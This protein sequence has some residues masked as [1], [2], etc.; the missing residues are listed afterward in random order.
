[1]IMS[2][3]LSL[4][5]AKDLPSY[6]G[7]LGED[8]TLIAVLG[9]ER[10]VRIPFDVLH[11]EHI[12]FYPTPSTPA[13]A[14]TTG[15]ISWDNT[16]VFTYHGGLWGKSP[17]ITSNW[18]DYTANSRFLLVSSAQSLS[19]E[20][21][22]AARSNLN[23]KSATQSE[24]GLVRITTDMNDNSGAVP[25]AAVIKSYIQ[26]LLQSGAS[27][28]P[29]SSI[30]L[31]NYVGPVNI[32]DSHG[33]ILLRYDELRK[34]LQIGNVTISDVKIDTSTQVVIEGPT[35]VKSTFEV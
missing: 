2:E 35:G 23:I 32:Q 13:A 8:T 15:A 22:S 18:G 10:T 27:S 6:S 5:N 19:A 3:Q 11:D 28:L 33:N 16:G 4:I 1:M 7:A 25:T 34:V 12:T 30:N 31:G 14:G 20:E 17:R 26:Q 29:G 24:E 21:I 9:N